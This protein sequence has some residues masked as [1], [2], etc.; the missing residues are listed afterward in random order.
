MW[1]GID[2]RFSSGELP[3]R[4]LVLKMAG[5]LTVGTLGLVFACPATARAT[6]VSSLVH[7]WKESRGIA[8]VVGPTAKTCSQSL[9]RGTRLQVVGVL[10]EWPAVEQA[11]KETAK[12]DLP[13]GKLTW[14]QGT[15]GSL[16]LADNLANL[17]VV[18]DAGAAVAGEAM[19]VLQ[20][21][22]TLWVDG[23]TRVKPVPDTIDDWTHPYYGPHNNPASQ[24]RAIRAPYMTQFLADPRYAPAPQFTV[25]AGGRVFK[26]YGH[27][28]WHEREEPY[29]NVIVVYDGFNGTQLWRYQLPEGMMVHRNVFIASPD[30]L[31]VGDDR[32]CKMIDTRTG[33]V[34]DEIR[35]PAEL[36]DGPFWK[37][38]AIQDGTLYALVGEKEFPAKPVKWKRTQHGW[39]WNQIS[40]GFNS[41]EQ[42]WGFGRTLLAIDLETK[43]VRWHYREDQPIDSRALCMNGDRLFAFRFGTYL[44]CLDAKTGKVVWRK[45]KNGSPELFE[46]LGEYLTRQ[47]WRTNWRTVVYLKCS[48][49]A[50]YFAGPQLSKMV[51]LSTEDGRLLWEDPYDNYQL[52]LRPHAVYAISGPWGVEKSKVFD[53]LTGKVLSELPIGRRACTRPTATMDSILFRAMG[54]SV[55]LDVAAGQPRWISPMRPACHDGVTIANGMLYWW[56]YVCDCQLSLNGVTALTSAGSFDFSPPADA[57]GRWVHND[58]DASGQGPQIDSADWPTFRANNERTVVTTAR[59]PAKARILWSLAANGKDVWLTAPI[60]VG[61]RLWVAGS[62]GIVRAVDASSGRTVGEYTTGGEIRIAPTYAQG[63]VY[64]GSG[65][66]WVYALDP[67]LKQPVWRYRAAPAE[68]W[69]PVYGSLLSTWPAASGVLVEDGVAYVAAGRVN[70]DGTYVYALDAATGKPRW[71]NDQ[72]GF[73]DPAAR[74]GVSVMGHLLWHGNRV[75]LAGGNAV[76]PAMYDAQ[77]GKCLNDPGP[78]SRCESTAPRG[79]ELFLVG[80]RVIACG[81]PFYSRPD[82]PV[83]DHTVQKKILHARSGRTDI[84]WLDNRVV[85]GFDPIP[86]EE[87]SACVTDRKT[88]RHITQAWGQFKVKQRPRWKYDCPGSVAL[89]VTANAVVVADRKK[90]VALKLRDG[91]QM[92]EVALPSAPVP[93]GLAVTRNGT[94]IATLENGTVV[95]VGEE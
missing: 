70:F 35:A 21:R 93:W 17:V 42:P 9:A 27:V 5:W 34:I 14:V 79:W 62:D 89:A 47:S 7:Q 65:D 24:D 63:L 86:A 66:G 77:T 83:Y 28:A 53:P 16:P 40:P 85:A 30:V 91:E 45:D 60:A 78:L 32:S 69:I 76:S 72:S 87:L 20:P 6:D 4:L 52:I 3:R 46:T 61:D 41:P 90:V 68:R 50:L 36:V 25:S 67:D 49:D 73:L 81:M 43:R 59:V 38:M 75:Y 18:T 44:T 95:A 2:V 55:R 57:E 82:L 48:Q 56:P 94:V 19:R 31:Y 88:P 37:W 8:V 29:L 54:G 13:P 11:R 1:H 71:C 15:D 74:T 84:V 23:R 51:V 58:F 26:I 92:W 12:G 39:P 33:S 80:D 10:S 64:V 22:G